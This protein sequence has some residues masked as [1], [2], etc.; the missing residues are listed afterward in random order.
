MIYIILSISYIGL[1]TNWEQLTWNTSWVRMM[2]S[3]FPLRT[4]SSSWKFFL[5]WSEHVCGD[6]FS[7]SSPSQAGPEEEQG[8]SLREGG[9]SVCR[10]GGLD[11]GL[12][13]WCDGSN[14]LHHYLFLLIGWRCTMKLAARGL[15]QSTCLGCSL[16]VELRLVS[17]VHC[18]VHCLEPY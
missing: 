14:P 13:H 10:A 17:M 9:G 3:G 18:F 7:V 15:L 11:C 6:T 4:A 12:S 8:S 2:L 16:E 1:M 5:G